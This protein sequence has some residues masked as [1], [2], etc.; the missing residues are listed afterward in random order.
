MLSTQQAEACGGSQQQHGAFPRELR[1]AG[2]PRTGAQG[3]PLCSHTPALPGLQVLGV[4]KAESRPQ[5]MRTRGAVSG[6]AAAPALAQ[7]STTA[8]WEGSHAEG[9]HR[10]QL[11]QPLPG[12]GTELGTGE[13]PQAPSPDTVAT[14][15][16]G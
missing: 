11:G 3:G 15:K 13:S 5:G 7:V 1:S 8:Q 6:L 12:T 4:Q 9:T 16:G 14:P 10:G 2:A